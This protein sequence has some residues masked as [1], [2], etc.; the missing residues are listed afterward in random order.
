M[1]PATHSALTSC[2]IG[3]AG[4]LHLRQHHHSSACTLRHL[5]VLSA[6]RCAVGTSPRFCTLLRCR[7]CTMLGTLLRLWHLIVPVG[8]ASESSCRPCGKPFRLLLHESLFRKRV[9]IYDIFFIPTN[10]LQKKVEFFHA[11]WSSPP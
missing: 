11:A 1:D 4:A 10:N 8:T 7:H 5:A 3:K 6:L 9:Q 2:L